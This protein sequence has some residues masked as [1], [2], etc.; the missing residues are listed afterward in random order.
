MRKHER[1]HASTLRLV[2]AARHIMTKR[3]GHSVCILRM[4]QLLAKQQTMGAGPEGGTWKHIWH[5]CIQINHRC[6]RLFWAEA[7]NASPVTYL[8]NPVG[9]S[10]SVP[11]T[12]EW[13]LC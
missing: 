6:A 12:F 3:V 8:T 13:H 9:G 2:F 11:L 4:Q 7:A 5:W 1:H 10:R